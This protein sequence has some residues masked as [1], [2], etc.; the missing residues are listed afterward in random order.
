MIENAHARNDVHSLEYERYH[1]IQPH[2]HV[3]DL[4]AHVGYFTEFVAPRCVFVVAF[5]PNP[6]NFRELAARCG[7]I[8]NATLIRAAAFDVAGQAMLHECPANNGAHS[9]FKHGQCSE[10]TWPVQTVAIGQWLR[11]QRSWFRPDF[12]K[13]DTEGAE[14]VIVESL[15]ACGIVADMA[16]ETHDSNL[17]W[18][19]RKA[20]EVAGHEWLPDTARVGVCYV[21]AKR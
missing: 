20:I 7:G 4:G 17:Y 11:D 12:I 2:E 8:G 15:M 14:G 3:L 19:C 1:A 18:R 9:L 6:D 5:E 16:I 21:K 10:V 13:I